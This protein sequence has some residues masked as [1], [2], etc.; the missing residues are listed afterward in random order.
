MLYPHQHKNRI[1]NLHYIFKEVLGYQP[2]ET[3]KWNERNKDFVTI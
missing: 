3:Q 2:Y 1:L